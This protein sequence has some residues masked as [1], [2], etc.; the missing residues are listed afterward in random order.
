MANTI[1]EQL[2][3]FGVAQVLVVLKAPTAA[4]RLPALSANLAASVPVAAS[5]VIGGI[6]EKI[7]ARLSKHFRT[8]EMS[9]DTALATAKTKGKKLA[10]GAKWFHK[11]K[12]IADPTPAARIYPNLG[13]M[14]GVVD[15]TGLNALVKSNDVSQVIAPPV[16]SLI[17]PT[18]VTAAL[19]E[20]DFTWGI[21]HI[22][23]DKLHAQGITGQGV[24]V[25]HLDTGIDG[26]HPALAP[27]IHSFA[28]FD[29]LGFEV[30]PTPT[31]FDS[32]EHGSHTAGTIAGRT[33]NQKAIGVAPM[34]MLASAIVIEGGNVIARILAGM[35]WAIGQQ[36]RILNMSLGLRGFTEDFLSL[37]QILRARGVLPVFAIGNEGAG[38]SRSPGNYS[39]AL[40][41]GAMGENKKVAGFSS[42]RLFNRPHDPIVPD[43]VAPGVGIISAKPGGEYQEM[44][45]TSMATPHVSGLA[46]L[47]MEA[48]PGKSIDQ[49]ESA[50]LNSCKPLAHEPVER[51][52]HGVPDAVK[53]L[54]L[55]LAM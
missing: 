47:L 52:N 38:T 24:I 11:A 33:V 14:F 34:A 4:T 41:I 46:A 55:L 42:S 32:E 26:T 15:R 31:P 30:T 50:I 10:A 49:V 18:A 45:G 29:D 40:S 12:N 20:K 7:V 2:S 43:L 53:A 25:G 13:I 17:R 23:A 36:A 16:L 44:D 39:E 35:D 54:S 9:L 51:Q 22:K 3:A 21:K 48:D 27:A 28:Q 5:K 8:S 37:T 1:E 19:A 6:A